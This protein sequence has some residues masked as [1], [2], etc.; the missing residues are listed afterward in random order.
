MVLVLFYLL[1]R[2]P[3]LTRRAGKRK[4]LQLRLV[5]CQE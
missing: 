3:A 2:F 1:R 5:R 4:R